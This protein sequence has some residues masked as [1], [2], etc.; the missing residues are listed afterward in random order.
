MTRARNT[1]VDIAANEDGDDELM[2]SANLR[3]PGGSVGGYAMPADCRLIIERGS[4]PYVFD[5][6]GR[7]FVDYVAGA[8]TLILGHSHPA[9]VSA[10]VDQIRK[11]TVF[12][13]S[14]T[15]PIIELANEMVRAIPC[16]EVVSFATT[17]SEATMY[18]MRM[19]RAHTRRQKILK[20]EGAY[21]GNHDYAQVATTPRA[22]S[23]YPSGLPDTAGTPDAVPPT[24]L[25]APFNDFDSF[26]AILSEHWRDTAAVIVEPIQRGIP[27]QPGF[28]EGLRRITSQYGVLL[29]FDEIVT[30]FRLAYGGAQEYFGV[31]P[32]LATYGKII[33]GGLALGA[34]AGAADIV[35][36]SNPMDRGKDGFVLVNGTQHGN[37]AAAAAGVA[38]LKELRRDAFYRALNSASADLRAELDKRMAARKAPAIITGMASLWHVVFADAP[39]VNHADM[40]RSDAARARAFDAELIR[41]GV[42]VLPGVRRLMTAAHDAESVEA[43]LAAM[44]R[45]LAKT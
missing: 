9:V 15:E 24:M 27:P 14:L 36:A 32:D 34:V 40:M 3:L 5:R 44:D 19:A 12:F 33:G 16:A 10:T 30:G 21:H 11:G 39:P 17:G 25:V 28:L 31:V 35:L 1:K 13:G 29:I 2:R 20:F 43:T 41:Q 26:A 45:A 38:M 22:I 18:A 37:V 7:R 6:S 23:N 4:G 42:L 8:G